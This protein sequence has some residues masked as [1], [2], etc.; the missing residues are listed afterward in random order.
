MERQWE[1]MAK[2]FH[3]GKAVHSF[4][5]V[6]VSKH[7][8]NLARD[9]HWCIVSY[10]TLHIYTKVCWNK[11]YAVLTKCCYT[12]RKRGFPLFLIFHTGCFSR[13]SLFISRY[14]SI[15]PVNVKS[16]QKNFS[17]FIFFIPSFYVYIFSLP[18]FIIT[19][20]PI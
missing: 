14:K 13:S 7:I 3:D 12:I 5:L 15:F 20:F 6:C 18:D 1:F 10:D 9:L 16:S 17:L 4:I 8:E 11:A 2:P 19:L